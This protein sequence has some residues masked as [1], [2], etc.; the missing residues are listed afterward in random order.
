M[1]HLLE[2]LGKKTR[3]GVH[4]HSSFC[5]PIL[6]NFCE[7]T[8]IYLTHFKYATIHPKTNQLFFVVLRLLFNRRQI[9]IKIEFKFNQI[10]T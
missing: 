8:V 9:Q 7:M 5:A 10:L 6:L 1:G 4:F 3:S 2:M